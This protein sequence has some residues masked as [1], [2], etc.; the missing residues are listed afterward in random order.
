ML[1]DYSR[2]IL[3]FYIGRGAITSIVRAKSSRKMKMCMFSR[4]TNSNEVKYDE[5]TCMY[6]ARTMQVW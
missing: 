1:S 3:Y 4:V 6:I 5:K 2:V